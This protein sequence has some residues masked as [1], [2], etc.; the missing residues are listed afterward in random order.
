MHAAAAEAS[1]LPFALSGRGLAFAYGKGQ[2][3]F[4][5]VSLD[6][7]PR[8]IVAL[9]GGSGCGVHHRVRPALRAVGCLKG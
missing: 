7:R 5:A 1:T 2:P 9:L 3:I 4:E 6:V 8:E